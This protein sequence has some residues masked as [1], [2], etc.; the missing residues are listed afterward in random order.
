MRCSYCKQE[1]DKKWNFCP[2]CGRKIKRDSNVM[3]MISRRLDQ[4]KS[5]FISEKYERRIEQPRNGITVS[6]IHGFRQPRMSIVPERPYETSYRQ[7]RKLPKTVIEPRVNIKRLSDVIVINVELP[8][9]KSEQDVVLNR[10]S[11][12]I[13]L[14]AY[15]GD[16][17]Y[18]KILKIPYRN[19]LIDKKLEKDNLAMKFSV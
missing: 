7:T 6:I 10:F 3:D 17:G 13:E 14:R 2:V 15:A 19:K 16:K 11:N 1:I 8:G 18:F 9:V 5:M 4:L 12:S